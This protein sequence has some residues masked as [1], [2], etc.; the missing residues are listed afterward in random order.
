[1]LNNK[2]GATVKNKTKKPATKPTNQKP[3][4]KKN[5]TKPKNCQPRA[6]NYSRLFEKAKDHGTM[7]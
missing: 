1:M 5:T 3:N 6:F 2:V 7:C 4:K